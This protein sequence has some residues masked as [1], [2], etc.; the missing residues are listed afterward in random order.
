VRIELLCVGRQ[1]NDLVVPGDAKESSASEIYYKGDPEYDLYEKKSLALK[2]KW[3]L[4]FEQENGLPKN[5]LS[6]LSEGMTRTGLQHC[7]QVKNAFEDFYRMNIDEKALEDTLS[8]VV[9][10]LRAFYISKGYNEAEFMPKLVESV[11]NT[12]RLFNIQG[13]GVASWHEGLPL[14]AEQNGHNRDTKDW[15]YYNSDYYYRSETMKDSLLNITQRIAMRYQVNPSELNLPTEFQDDDFR[16]SIYSSY[17]AYVNHSARESRHI[18]NIV[19]ETIP[20]PQGLRFFYKANE[21]GTNLWVP[22]LDAPY[23]EAEATF[24]GVL[25][26]WY[27]DWSFVGRV[28]VRQNSYQFPISVNMSDVVEKGSSLE[29]PEGIRDYL[30]NIDFFTVV[31]SNIY[32]SAHPRKL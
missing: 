3:R 14:A 2:E 28:P 19:D 13:A 9:A 32:M 30:H 5:F 10:D 7:E 12:A 23:D 24:D 20:P 29:I 8:D 6:P 22:K 31:Q 11:Y 21:S 16:K 4:A 18:G 25:Q 1:K 17:T 26:V 27:G 15:F